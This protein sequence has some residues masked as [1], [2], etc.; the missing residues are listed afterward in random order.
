MS[1][2]RLV[3]IMHPIP[4]ILPCRAVFQNQAG[5]IKVKT[6]DKTQGKQ[7]ITKYKSKK[8]FLQDYPSIGEALGG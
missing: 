8:K 7:S 4:E 3:G 5:Q 2:W 6:E 1:D